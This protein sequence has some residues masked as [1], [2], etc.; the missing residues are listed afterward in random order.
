MAR[1]G[2]GSLVY[3]KTGAI[4][5]FNVRHQENNGTD[6]TVGILIIINTENDDTKSV[7]VN[8]I[9]S[10]IKSSSDLFQDII[11]EHDA[12]NKEITLTSNGT[13][14]TFKVDTYMEI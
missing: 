11:L 12:E 14:R 1:I 4:I 6:E 9:W 2:N 5:A 10:I 7:T 13:S 8:S 3:G